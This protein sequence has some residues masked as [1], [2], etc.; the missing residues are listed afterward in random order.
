MNI[1]SLSYEDCTNYSLT[2]VMARSV[3]LKRDLRLATGNAYSGYDELNIRSY[4]S[5]N[6]DSYDRFLIRMFE[7][8]ESLNIVSMVSGQ[9]D[10]TYFAQKR[11]TY[12]PLVLNKVFYKTTK[13]SY[14]SMEDLIHSFLF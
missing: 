4:C 14:S 9:L 1:G 7:M 2:G 11:Y 6:G 10:K 8:A 3:G 13:S 5:H 12:T